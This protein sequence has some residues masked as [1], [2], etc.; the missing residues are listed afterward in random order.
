[1]ECPACKSINPEPASFCT[2]CGQDLR[3]YGRRHAGKRRSVWFWIGAVLLAISSWFWLLLIIAMAADPEDSL[4]LIVGGAIFSV[5][6]I[7]IGIYCVKRGQRP[8]AMGDQPFPSGPGPVPSEE[9][10]AS[11]G[12]AGGKSTQ[13]ANHGMV[14]TL[15]NALNHPIPKPIAAIG[16]V[17]VIMVIAIPLVFFKPPAH[18]PHGVKLT[19]REVIRTALDGYMAENELTTVSSQAYTNSFAG[20]VLA[21]FLRRSTTTY[22]YR[23]DTV[24][25]VTQS[26][27]RQSVTVCESAVD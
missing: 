14:Q 19:E 26:D 17:F 13:E 12:E 24:G 7:A 2:N 25:R 27:D 11:V 8:Q 18:E 1:M 23:W 15:R 21:D 4:D 22:C 6:P 9:Y 5:I 10:P 3:T 16:S 20:T